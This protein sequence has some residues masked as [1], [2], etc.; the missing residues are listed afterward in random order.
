MIRWFQC[1]LSVLYSGNIPR[2]RFFLTKRGM[3]HGEEKNTS[4]VISYSLRNDRLRGSTFVMNA[5]SWDLETNIEVSADFYRG[6]TKTF[7]DKSRV[8][9]RGLVIDAMERARLCNLISN[10]PTTSLKKM[11]HS[12]M[13][14]LD[15]HIYETHPLNKSQECVCMHKK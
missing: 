10:F 11:A 1:K 7:I 6:P 3:E 5:G 8:S 9:N 14:V 13:F 2:S 4:G 12:S 15:I